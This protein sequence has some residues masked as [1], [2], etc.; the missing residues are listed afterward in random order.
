MVSVERIVHYAELESEHDDSDAKEPDSWPTQGHLKVCFDIVQFFCSKTIRFF[1]FSLKI[2]TRL[3]GNI[4]SQDCLDGSC[5]LEVQRGGI[6]SKGHLLGYQ[7]ERE[8]WCLFC[9]KRNHR[10]TYVFL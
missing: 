8:G 2:D 7:A 9:L 3:D 10:D 1:Y 6:R 4:T 5:S